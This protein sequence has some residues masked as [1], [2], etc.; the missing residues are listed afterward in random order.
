MQKPLVQINIVSDIVCPWCYIGKRRIE[1]A[2]EALKNEYAF[3]INYLPFELNSDMPES[4]SN[5]KAYL[6][7]KF[8]SEE[9]FKQIAQHV[10]G[11]AKQEGLEFNFEK[12]YISPNTRAAHQI[13]WKAKQSGKQ[14]EVVEA[15]FKA[16]FTD[17]ID[18]TKQENLY[19]VAE[20]AGM[21][22]SEVD[23]ALNEEESLENV[24]MLQ[25]NNRQM[26]I[27]G[28]PYYIVNNKYAISGAQPAEIFIE[29][30][31]DISLKTIVD[32]EACKVE[33]KNC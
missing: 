5:Q 28:V 3:E 17:G 29:A 15:F 13:I 16:Y 32:G 8:G 31:K 6:S 1:R 22:Q 2:I 4:G 27:S 30:I 7:A 9:K 20:S 21:I 23:N 25:L 11:I 33:N 19:A 10:T 18:L 14:V 24:I 12:Q 26:G